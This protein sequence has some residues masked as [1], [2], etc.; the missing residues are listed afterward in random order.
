MRGGAAHHRIWQA[1]ALEIPVP[2]VIGADFATLFASEMPAPEGVS[3]LPLSGMISNRRLRMA[4][5]RDIM[6]H[7][8]ASAEIVLEGTASPR[9]TALEGP[10]GAIP[11]SSSSSST[12]AFAKTPAILRPSPDAR[13]MSV[14]CSEAL[15]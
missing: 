12:C 2:V 3:E 11:S 6:L 13:P 1:R 7:V 5:C 9:E 10:F 14:Q 4:P 15:C 8:P